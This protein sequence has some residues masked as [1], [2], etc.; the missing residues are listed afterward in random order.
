[1]LKAHWHGYEIDSYAV[2]GSPDGSLEQVIAVR[3]AV[4]TNGS[5]VAGGL[6]VSAATSTS[7]V[8]TYISKRAP[9]DSMLVDNHRE[10]RIS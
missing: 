8:V 2:K 7:A 9:F 6:A 5:A 4:P 1:M 10:G 3:D